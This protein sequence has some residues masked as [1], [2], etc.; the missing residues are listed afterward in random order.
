MKKINKKIVVGALSL[1]ILLPIAGL[2][3]ADERNF[4]RNFDSDKRE[5]VILAIQNNNFDDFIAL[6]KIDSDKAE[7]IFNYKKNLFQDKS[8]DEI[9]KMKSDFTKMRK[10]ST[11]HHSNNDKER[12]A[13]R[14]DLK[15]NIDK[16]TYSNF[17]EKVGEEKFERI[18]EDNYSE[19]KDMLKDGKRFDKHNHEMKN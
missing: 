7:K 6:T 8:V 1:A 18:N 10:D 9:T 12:R 3:L 16:Y 11:K 4:K 13:M 14:V 19:F 17:R 2:S 15:N 5:A